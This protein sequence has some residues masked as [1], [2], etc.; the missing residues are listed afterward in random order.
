[1]KISRVFCQ[2]F[3]EL[4]LAAKVPTKKKLRAVPVKNKYIQLSC[5]SALFFISCSEDREK[6][7]G[8]LSEK[9]V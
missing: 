7:R 9:K 3:L 4:F 5:R 6:F 1:M 2:F 8:K